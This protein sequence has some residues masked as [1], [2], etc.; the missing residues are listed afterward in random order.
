MDSSNQR[1]QDYLFDLHGYLHLKNAVSKND[2]QEMNQWVDAHWEHVN[3]K[4][5]R[6]AGDDSGAWIGRVETHTYGERDGLNFQ[7]II[8][9]RCCIRAIN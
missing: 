1:L 4:K 9:A 5:R 8:E 7:N 3:D 2:V 6:G